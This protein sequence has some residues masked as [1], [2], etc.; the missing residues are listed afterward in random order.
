MP[1]RLCIEPGCALLTRGSRCPG[2]E[3]VRQ[4]KRWQDKTIAKVV[5]EAS[6]VCSCIGCRLHKGPCGA[7]VDLTADHPI[8]LAKGGTNEQ[9]RVVLCR[10]CNS[11]KGIKMVATK[12]R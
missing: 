2:H 11:S 5:V 1:V 10:R 6:P 4:S 8:A 12:R 7:T 9:R 3:H